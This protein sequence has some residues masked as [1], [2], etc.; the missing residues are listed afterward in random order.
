MTTQII[1]ASQGL[2]TNE[3]QLVAEYEKYSLAFP[4]SVYHP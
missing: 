1:E 3:M 4:F 2:I